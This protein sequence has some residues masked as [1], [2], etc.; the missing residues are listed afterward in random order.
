MTHA[1]DRAELQ[2]WLTRHATPDA[3]QI[4]ALARWVQT[5]T[6]YNPIGSLKPPCCGGSRGNPNWAHE[7][8]HWIRMLNEYA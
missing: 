8:N 7:Y 6:G 5:V 1:Y 3:G 2:A 4:T